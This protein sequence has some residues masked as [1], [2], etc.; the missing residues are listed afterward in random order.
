MSNYLNLPSDSL[1][2]NSLSNP[3]SFRGEIN[4][5]ASHCTCTCVNIDACEITRGVSRE[6]FGEQ[7][8]VVRH[9]CVP[10]ESSAGCK[11][12]RHLLQHRGWEIRP[13]SLS[14]D[15]KGSGGKAPLEIPWLP[16]IVSRW[17]LRMS[18]DG[19][20]PTAPLGTLGFSLTGKKR[21]QV[22]QGSSCVPFVPP[23]LAL[24]TLEEPGPV[25]L[26][27]PAVSLGMDEILEPS[28]SP[29]FPSPSPEET[30]PS[31]HPP[32]AIPGWLRGVQV[33]LH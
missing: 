1:Q 30:F 21:S 24:G 29:G 20:L 26:P 11:G 7:Q 19:K 10:L 4:P 16:R 3:S 17:F 9:R 32:C 6:Q 28:R 12:L 5:L 18:R 8:L 33:S 25:P 13:G 15:Q 31:F 22:F 14:Q 23:A 27:V 2:I